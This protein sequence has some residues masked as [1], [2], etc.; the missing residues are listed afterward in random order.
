MPVNRRQSTSE[1]YI[2][3]SN[4]KLLFGGLLL[5]LVFLMTLAFMSGNRRRGVEETTLDYE[6]QMLNENPVEISDGNLFERGDAKLRIDPAQVEMNNVVIGSKAEAILTLTAENTAIQFL[7]MEL[8]EEQTDGFTLETTCTS[9]TPIEVGKT[10]SI[11]VFWNPVALRQLQN[12]LT[13]RWKEYS[14]TAFREQT[15]TVLIK[16]QST[17]SKDCVICENVSNQEAKEARM[18]MGLNGELYE[19]DDEGYI[20]MPD[21]TR[22]KVTENGIVVDAQGNIVAVV[23]PEYI[24][25]NL[26]NDLM[27]TISDTKEVIGANG[28]KFGRM[29]GDKTIVD[30]KLTVLGA[31][32]PVVSVINAQGGVVGKMTKDGTVVDGQNK[33][34]GKVWV[35]GQVFSLENQ[36][37]G[38]VRPWG[39]VAN[40]SGKVIGAIIPDG[41]VIDGK[42]N[43]I[44][45]IMPNGFAIGNQGDL[46]GA[47]IPQGVGVGQGCQ[48]VGKVLLNGDVKDSYDQLV[49]KVL[50]D[51]TIIN[52]EGDEIGTVIPQGLI[53]NEKGTVVGFINS[54]GKAVNGKGA[55]VGCV[56]PDGTVVAGKKSIGSVLTRG[57]VIGYGCQPIG[58]VFP[59]GE[60]FDNT[61]KSVGHVLPDRYVR[62]AENKV[63]GL[64][65]TRGVAIA[66]GCRMLG[67]VSLTGQ[68]L[69]MQNQSVGCVTPDKTIINSSGEI[70]GRLAP[71][72]GVYNKEGIL[73]GRVS[74]DGKVRDKEGNI[75]GCVNPDGT[76]TDTNGKVIGEV[77]TQAPGVVV[78][79]SGNPTGWSK[80]GNKVF[81]INGNEVGVLNREGVVVSET[82][83]YVG[84][85]PKEGHIFSP[86]GLILGRYSSKVGYAV[87]QNNERFAK[88][89]FDM[90]AISGDTNEIVGGLIPD[91][92]GFVDKNGISL[93]KVQM[94]G[95][96]RNK[97][98]VVIGAIRGVADKEGN[99]IGFKV[100]E[101][102]VATANGTVIGTVDS[103]GVVLSEGKTEI[104]RILG[105]GLAVSSDGKKLIGGVM[106]ASALAFDATGLVGYLNI[107]GEVQGLSG[108]VIGRA[109][110]FGFVLAEDGRAI[111]KLMRL[112]VFVDNTGRTVGWTSLEGTLTG[113]D[114]KT[115]GKI[116]VAGLA[117]DRANKLVGSMVK[118]GMVV[119]K[120]GEF[121]S[122]MSVNNRV[123]QK[124]KLLGIA[125]ASPYIYTTDNVVLGQLLPVGIAISNDGTLLGWTRSDGSIGTQHETVGNVL[126]DHRVVNTRGHIIGSYVPLGSVAYDND[127]KTVG[128]VSV[129]GSIISTT[130]QTRGEVRGGNLIARDGEI[131]GRLLSDIPYVSNNLTG[132]TNGLS[133]LTGDVVTASGGKTVGNL[134][135][136]GTV[137]NLARQVIGQM[138]AYG[139]PVTNALSSLGQLYL[140]GEVASRS[141]TEGVVSGTK[142]IYDYQNRVIGSVLPTETV[143]GKTGNI[144]GRSAGSNQI[145]DRNGKQT[146]VQMTFGMALMPDN[147]WVGGIIPSGAVVNDDGVLIGTIS[148]DGIVSDKEEL[149][150]GRVLSDGS[151]VAVSDRELYN[152]MPYAG[153]VVVQGLPLNYRGTVMGTTTV[154]GD[155]LDLTAAKI[156]RILDDGTILGKE[157]PL[158]GTVLPFLPAISQTGDVMGSLNGRG[159]IVSPTGEIVGK[160]AVNETVKG[161]GEYEIL[162]VLVPS[163]TITNDCKMVGVTALNGQ[164]INA[165]GTVVGRVTPDK[166]AVNASGERIGHVTRA[167][168]VVSSDGTFLGRTLPDSTVVDTQGVSLGCA[169]NDGSVT[170]NS[171]NIIG[172]VIERGLVLGKDG[173]PLGRVKANGTIVDKSGREIGKIRAD[174][175]AINLDGH[176]IGH[177]VQRDQEILF[178]E[179]GNVKGTLGADGT[180]YEPQSG[181]PVFR[182]DKD[183]N[184]YD[185]EGNLIGK[186]KNGEFMDVKGNILDGM[187]VLL[188]KDGKAFGIISG[189]DILNAYGEK[190]G[191][192]LANGNVVDLNGNVF[193]RILGDGTILQ[194]GKMLGKVS[195]TNPRLDKCG[196]QTTFSDSTQIVGRV[197]K[198]GNMYDA[199]GNLVG[200]IDEK[201]NVYD[202]DGKLIGRVDKDG[203]IYDENGNLIGFIDKDGKIHLYDGAE[204]AGMR[205][206]SGNS[207]SMDMTVGHVDANGNVYDKNGNLVARIDKNGNIYDKNGN[208]IGRVD[209]NG[210]VYDKDG[211][212]IGYIDKNGNLN[213]YS[214]KEL[215]GLKA[216]GDTIVGRVGSDG[217]LY[218]KNGQKI[219]YVDEQGNIFDKDGNKIGYIKDG[220][221]YDMN[222]NPV[223]YVDANGNIHLYDGEKL[224]SLSG[225]ARGYGTS[226][227]AI[228][229]GNQKYAVSDKGSI[230]NSDGTIIGYMGEDGRPYTLDNRVLTSSGDITGRS[231]P[232]IF[233]RPTVSQEQVEQMQNLLTQKRQSMRA[234]IKSVIKPDGRI[235]AKSKLR[236]ASD[237]GDEF[238]T[239][240]SWP[241]DMSRMILQDKAIPAV[242]VRSIDSRYKDVPVT[243]I[244]ERN[245]YSEQGRNILIPAG[246]RVI[247]KMTGTPGQDKVAKME[248]SW[249]RLIRP[250]GGMFKF[251]ATSG[252][253]QGR[254][255]V[256]AYLDD[257]LITKYGKPI[258][259]SVVTSAVSYMMAANDDYTV[260]NTSDTTTQSSKSKAADDARENFIQ[261]MQ[262]I[263]DQLI[264]E[265][266]NVPPVVFVPSG[267]RVT[268]FSTTD[269]WLRSEDDDIKDYEDRNGTDTTEARTPNVNSWVDNR[270]Q[271]IDTS[272][273]ESDSKNESS[274]DKKNKSNEEDNSIDYYTPNDSYKKRSNLD[275]NQP[276]SG[277]NEPVYDGNTQPLTEEIS[278]KDRT[279]TP[280]LPKTG[281]AARLF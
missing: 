247:G 102:N 94:D 141:K 27:G 44:A 196:I 199:N 177:V 164:V 254:G 220:I 36:P 93:G 198:N 270:N 234:G 105:S 83:K 201:G 279:V 69:D 52:S 276:T 248:I 189:C 100:I 272:Y 91:N 24:A 250:D 5:L 90:T 6:N 239:V 126:Y 49:G 151:V 104:G 127:G 227:R 43:T 178:D 252:D 103:S 179:N 30:P 72:G 54:E 112:G 213:L 203:N 246:S 17:D 240:S 84:F 187:T 236:R 202:A 200:H 119:G 277:S 166:W 129:N 115:A 244:V 22:L 162:G 88:I 121:I 70:M 106:P 148:A 16:A 259:T 182:V 155:V 238:K 77:S 173:K 41:T 23:E 64:V 13:I 172:S 143:I 175:S 124:D 82:G 46:I 147:T 204:L 256:A 65:V 47:T 150:T 57:H 37:I 225:A 12:N 39:L 20:T 111:A 191:T 107:K 186:Y 170:D 209:E 34:I 114:N 218:D 32:I 197:D 51:G 25:L 134:M 85:I 206:I 26:N 242:I 159:Q 136:N 11:K 255:G 224:G 76:V 45:R 278:L 62:N 262:Q 110:P 63:I 216:A 120:N 184:V 1:Q 118:Q 18:A 158:V 68:V 79:G 176:V 96:L 180:F 171:G 194:N 2:K 48:L 174:G 215:A 145:I 89:L 181:K 149:V 75:V 138:T 86:D 56:N 280:V 253:A 42:N 9:S 128:L 125:T 73:I 237:W 281:T 87:N 133:Q 58:S 226:G 223:G 210:N 35:D 74:F 66:D 156:F 222:G 193:A 28:E 258:M 275:E 31:G 165:R 40:F 29:L 98:G 192:V 142:A 245:I 7:G 135:M 168:I 81:D 123:L 219:G 207:D 140:N 241:V 60:V 61:L 235:L 3:K 274:K 33:V 53:I 92:T 232:N 157:E 212:L 97:E 113:T 59:N 169:R 264:S 261:A 205:G 188:D 228:Y 231:R 273:S 163:R 211:N 71:R 21:G 152:T 251:Q 267:T 108:E 221:V 10:C 8:A 243:A 167:G 154:N 249:S 99:I 160:I 183:G 144:I 95:T 266:T 132:K 229:I 268:I 131:V 161:P 269:L 146:A 271:S 101:G 38:Y 257:Q 50:L 117:F 19:V 122:V 185:P 109:S 130:G 217:T 153:H 208:L 260:N 15:S 263:F 233:Q 214:G 139:I 14:Q 55:V 190:I 230:I 67:F 265:A 195:G 78:D 116:N 137:L 4:R 80:V